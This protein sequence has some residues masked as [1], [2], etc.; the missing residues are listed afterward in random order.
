MATAASSLPPATAPPPPGAPAVARVESLTLLLGNDGACRL[1]LVDVDAEG[2]ALDLLLA[3][4]HEILHRHRDPALDLRIER[5]ERRSSL[6]DHA[7]VLQV[8]RRV[9]AVR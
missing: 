7:E 9:G 5:R 2:A 4:R 8:L 3:L 1:R 6:A